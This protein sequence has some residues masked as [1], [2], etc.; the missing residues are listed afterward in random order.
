MKVR[1]NLS[2]KPL[3]THRR[4]LASA[5]VIS[6]VAGIFF[7]AMGWHVYSVRKADEAQRVKLASIRQEMAGLEQQRTDLEKFFALD[8]NAKLHDRS[9]F[10]NT[11]IDEQSLNWTQMFMDLEKILPAG[12]RVMSIEPK[13]EKGRVE[14]KLIVG[15]MND[16]V[17]L[18][19]LN[20]LEGS[21]AFSHVQLVNQ[22]EATPGTPGP[23]RL[24]VE[25]K[26]DYSR[27]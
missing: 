16:E 17:K 10:L 23:D 27:T 11:L 8:A 9:A 25:L 6:V 1:L 22:K 21:P 12:V 7:L 4:F 19:F 14:V 15:A 5:G 2:T 13:H 3:E 20:A 26:V 18:K 24:E